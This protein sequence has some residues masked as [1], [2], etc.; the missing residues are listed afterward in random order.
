VIKNRAARIAAAVIVAGGLAVAPLLDD[1]EATDST[2]AGPQPADMPQFRILWR[3]D[4]VVLAGHT[5]SE[6]HEKDLAG[7]AASHYPNARIKTDFKPLGVVPGY[8]A[9]VSV[10]TLYLLAAT[11]SAEATISTTGIAVRGVIDDELGWQN[12]LAAYQSALR[13]VL[14]LATDTL[15]VNSGSGVSDICERAFSTVAPGRIEFEESGTELRSSAYPRLDR[16]IALVRT[17]QPFLILITGHTDAS[18]TAALND[19]LS[20]RR[21]E[22]VADYFADGGIDR[23]RLVVRG[24]G[25]TQP[26]ADDSTRH[27][28]SLN[29]RIEIAFELP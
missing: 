4:E 13:G 12:R 20:L 9:D 25:A 28:R 26:I 1:G 16:V 2:L 21:A 7:V 3:S 15:F 10:R 23:A 24:A 29:R 14:S 8:W 11:R 6:Q 18:G 19:D 17:C 22:L 27:G 5:V